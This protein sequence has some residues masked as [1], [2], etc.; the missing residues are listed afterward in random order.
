MSELTWKRIRMVIRGACLANFY[1]FALRT[2]VECMGI[3]H[4]WD[5]QPPPGL[6]VWNGWW[7]TLD[8]GLACLMYVLHGQ[9]RDTDVS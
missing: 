9:L 5:R 7:M 2:I 3:I 6:P 1:W 4:N 8:A